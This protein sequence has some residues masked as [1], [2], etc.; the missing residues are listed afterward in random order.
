MSEAVQ[1]GD[2]GIPL[3]GQGCVLAEHGRGFGNQGVS[4]VPGHQVQKTN[5]WFAVSQ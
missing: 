4:S 2:L 1:P 5:S 3:I